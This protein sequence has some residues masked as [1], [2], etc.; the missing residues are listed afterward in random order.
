MSLSSSLRQM[1]RSNRWLAMPLALALAACGNSSGNHHA[2]V[3]HFRFD[4]PG[5]S[6]QVD[7]EAWYPAGAAKETFAWYSSAVWGSAARNA[8][9]LSGSKKPLIILAHGWRGTRFDLSWIGEAFA[10]KGFVVASLDMPDVDAKT[11]QDA[12]APKVWYRASLIKSLITA[13]NGNAMLRSN[14]DSEHV[15]VIGHSAGGSAA[16]M[17]GGAELD[18]ERFAALF[19][20]SAPAID[21]DWNDTRVAGVVALN[22]GT[23]PAF[24]P[25]GLAEVSVPTLILS[26]TG[27]N[28]APEATNAGFYAHYIPHASWV[29]FDDVDHYTFMPVCSAY[30]ML[31]RFSTCRESHANVQRADI[32]ART[33]ADIE[34]FVKQVTTAEAGKNS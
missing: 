27:D 5:L 12:Q 30:G 25:Q 20:Q 1:I 22:P 28:V 7:A 24:S 29:S 4:Y 17:L 21:G 2:G 19:P 15:I 31:R 13:V 33:L 18:P 8:P 10:R 32:H 9:M 11:F 34:K 16:L 3:T 6:R 14:T 26:G 23:G